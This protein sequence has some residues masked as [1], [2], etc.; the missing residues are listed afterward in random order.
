MNGRRL[1]LDVEAGIDDCVAVA[2]AAISGMLEAVTCV[3]G[4][5]PVE[6][7]V[8]NARDVLEL[9]GHGE[10]HVFQGAPVAL[11]GTPNP[12]LRKIEVHGETGSGYAR[13]E[14]GT[15]RPPTEAAAEVIVRLARSHPGRYTLVTGGPLTNLALA[16]DIEPALPSLL[17]RWV[18]MGGAFQVSGNVVGAEANIRADIVGARRCFQAFVGASPLPLAVSLRHDNSRLAVGRRGTRSTRQ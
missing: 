8:A 4:A 2:C 14:R 13:L 10:I 9:A 5:M 7:A 1:I 12:L 15:S 3:G 17:A 18:L 6:Q 16:L 11:G